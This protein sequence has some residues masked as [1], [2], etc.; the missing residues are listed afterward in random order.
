M[1]VKP[2]IKSDIVAA[3]DPITGKEPNNPIGQD[4]LSCTSPEI[5]KWQ[6]EDLLSDIDI[7]DD[8]KKAIELSLEQIWT[9]A[10]TLASVEITRLEQQILDLNHELKET[11]EKN[12]AI[13]AGL[14]DILRSLNT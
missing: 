9:T 11:R 2:S 14:I 4:R 1:D 6:Q 3:N 13:Q 8:L 7:P 10:N 12:R 5:K